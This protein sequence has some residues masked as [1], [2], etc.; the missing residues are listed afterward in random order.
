L[1]VACG[2][3]AA[4]LVEVDM[5]GCVAFGQSIFGVPDGRW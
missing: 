1:D 3:K 2:G 4:A 5:F